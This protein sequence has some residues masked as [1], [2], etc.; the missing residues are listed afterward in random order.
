LEGKYYFLQKDIYMGTNS[1]SGVTLLNKKQFLLGFFIGGATLTACILLAAPAS[2]RETRQVVRDQTKE[3]LNY[4]SELKESLQDLN[5]SIKTATIE[6]TENIKSFISDLTTAVTDW[7]KKIE[8]H[9]EELIKELEAIELSI[10][11]LE[12]QIKR[13]KHTTSKNSIE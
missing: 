12:S 9:Q 11:T 2:G 6:S 7:K 10:K 13:H 4:L 5:K 3:W 1:F 8:P